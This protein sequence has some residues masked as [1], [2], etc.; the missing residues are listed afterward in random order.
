MRW[1]NPSRW[2]RNL[3]EDF[4]PDENRRSYDS[5]LTPLCP[6]C[7]PQGSHPDKLET[8]STLTKLYFAGSAISSARVATSAG[9]STML[10]NANA[11]TISTRIVIVSASRLFTGSAPAACRAPLVE[12][13]LVR[14]MSYDH[15]V[16][17]SSTIRSTWQRT[18]VIL[19]LLRIANV[20]TISAEG[21]VQNERIATIV[22]GLNGANHDP[23]RKETTIVITIVVETYI[24]DPALAPLNSRGGNK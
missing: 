19:A 7:N 6:D 9:S 17:L 21:T 8:I 24:I 15:P 16:L 12:C 1:I 11:C 20:P 13:R 5:R 14:L 18:E 2:E 10:T 3:C 4:G 23:S 22:I